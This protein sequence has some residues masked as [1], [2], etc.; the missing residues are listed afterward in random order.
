MISLTTFSVL[1]LCSFSCRFFGT[2]SKPAITKFWK[3]QRTIIT[4]SWIIQ[5][6]NSQSDDWVL[7]CS[8]VLRFSAELPVLPRLKITIEL[9]E[10]IFIIHLGIHWNL[11]AIIL[12]SSRCQRCE[13]WWLF[14]EWNTVKV[15][16]PECRLLDSGFRN[17]QFQISWIL[18]DWD[19][20]LVFII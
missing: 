1:D 19:Y 11:Q 16:P 9:K 3:T 17:Y 8:L 5:T 2:E 10:I 14:D 18:W 4:W 13:L 12:T 7:D 15:I 6:E 20:S